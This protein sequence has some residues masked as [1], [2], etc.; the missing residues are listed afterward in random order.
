VIT[1]GV[2]GLGGLYIAWHANSSAERLKKYEVTYLQKRQSYVDLGTSVKALMV[3]AGGGSVEGR[4]LARR[5]PVAHINAVTDAQ[6][7]VSQAGFEAAP[8]M[9]D[10][11]DRVWMNNLVYFVIDRSEKLRC[12]VQ[13][14]NEATVQAIDKD[15]S[16]A[17]AEMI[18]QCAYGKIFKDDLKTPVPCSFEPPAP[19]PVP[20]PAKQ[21]ASGRES[22]LSRAR[23][24]A[25][26]P[27][28]TR[29]AHTHCREEDS[30]ATGVDSPHKC[31]PRSQQLSARSP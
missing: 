3:V 27:S 25:R 16:T 10:M 11:R 15:N 22:G 26:R 2:L 8:F 5:D 17:L 18:E 31:L 9:V 23:G 6:L 7:K 4:A 30:P 20:P 21:V 29:A 13:A 12:A 28:R 14:G 1:S 24:A 19:T